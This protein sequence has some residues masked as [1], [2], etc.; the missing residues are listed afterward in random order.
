M[1]SPPLTS[2][3]PTPCPRHFLPYTRRLRVLATAY[4]TLMSLIYPFAT[5][6]SRP[7]AVCC[8]P[9]SRPSKPTQIPAAP[10]ALRSRATYCM[11]QLGRLD[12]PPLWRDLTCSHCPQDPSGRTS[13]PASKPAIYDVQC[14][15]MLCHVLLSAMVCETHIPSNR[16][17]LS[18][19]STLTFT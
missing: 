13:D 4:P 14:Y 1:S 15:T 9:S 19:R 3:A 16:G 10:L 11:H 17:F 5:T 2:Y 7:A 18:G 6:A 12:R 8:S